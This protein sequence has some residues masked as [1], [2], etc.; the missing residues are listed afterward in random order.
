MTEGGGFRLSSVAHLESPAGRLATTLG[1][2]R[3][4]ID[5]ADAG[6]LFHHVTRIPI[7]HAGAR[8]LPANDFARW[9][10][11]AL[12]DPG[13]AE[14]LAFAGSRPLASLEEVRE[15]LLRALDR[16]PARR[17]AQ[18][19]P[20][21]A[22][23]H[24]VRARSVPAEVGVELREPAELVERWQYVDLST[25]FYHLIEAPV[26]GPEQDRLADWLRSRGAG[27][28]A[29]AAEELADT[30][31]PLERLRRE[32]GT[33]WR[34]LLIPGRLLRRLEGTEAERRADAHSAAERLAERLRG[35]PRPEDGP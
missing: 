5:A 19:A 26:L 18:E 4:G 34:R 10:S 27:S 2:L 33:R 20:E 31:R 11:N 17:R 23:F 30:G 32:I 9:A 35:S 12:Q 8:D 3:D 15:Q 24:F 22:A 13:T 14:Q 29:R 1:S 16:I 25:V 21:E 28:L 6:V 7:R